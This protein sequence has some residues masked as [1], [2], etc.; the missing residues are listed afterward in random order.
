MKKRVLAAIVAFAVAVAMSAAAVCAEEQ[1]EEAQ[2][3]SCGLTSGAQYTGMVPLYYDSAWN[4]GYFYSDMTEDGLVVV[5]NCCAANGAHAD[6]ISKEFREAFAAMVSGGEVM[7]Y[8]D[9]QNQSLTERF[10]YPVYDLAFVTGKNEDSCLWKMILFQTDTHTYAYAYRMDADAAEYMEEEYR[11]AV[12]SLELMD[13]SYFETGEMDY[14]PSANGESL[15]DFIAYFDVWY[16]CGDLNAESIHLNGDGTW[17]FYNSINEDG[18]GGYLFDDGTFATSGTTALQLY[19]ADGS[20][21]ADVRLNEYDELVLTPVV[22]GYAS[23]DGDAVFSREA[24]S[25]AYEAQTA[26]Y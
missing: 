8:H 5:V 25:V 15:E 1:M 11:H 2:G 23:F 24:E 19:S 26:E 6:G 10:S 4:G 21:V 16:L 20:Y 7:D 12:E 13:L 22:S 3:P 9:G 14:D 18:T 17:A